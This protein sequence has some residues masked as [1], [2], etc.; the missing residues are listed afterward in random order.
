MFNLNKP[1]GQI[2]SFH[3]SDIDV[4]NLVLLDFLESADVSCI[5]VVKHILEVLC[6]PPVLINGTESVMLKFLYASNPK[7][8]PYFVPN[9]RERLKLCIA[10]YDFVKWEPVL[11]GSDSKDGLFPYYIPDPLT[12]P[13][14]EIR[15]L[16][17]SRLGFSI[18]ALS[19]VNERIRF[20]AFNKFGFTQAATLDQ[21]QQ[22][23]RA[24]YRTLG[25]SEAALDDVDEE[26][27]LAAYLHLGWEERAK[28]D[29]S[30]RIRAHAVTK[31]GLNFDDL[32]NPLITINTLNRVKI[33]VTHFFKQLLKNFR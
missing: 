21:S 26:I 16:A 23:R 9:E 2:F 3:L 4:N 10:F 19:D 22:I 1:S 30:K 11:R 27:R 31:L 24:A 13:N 6:Y 14:S 25:Y 12:D 29:S 28:L 18:D 8:K 5:S 32:S 7:T 20:C 17:Y 33:S 15:L